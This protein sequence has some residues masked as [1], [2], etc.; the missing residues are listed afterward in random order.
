MGV[1]SEQAVV[2]LIIKGQNA[3]AT[4]KDLEK[5]SRALRAQMK[6]LALDSQEFADKQKELQKVEKRLRTIREELK[7]TGGMFQAIGKEIKAFGLIAVAAFGFQWIKGKVQSIIQNN[8]NLS[9]SFA[10]I[11]KTTEMTNREVKALNQTFSQMDTRTPTKELREIAIGAGQLG[12]AKHDV[13]EFTSAIDKMVVSL[14]DEFTGGAFEV[15]KTMGGLRNIFTDIKTDRVDQDILHIGNAVNVLAASGAATGP[16]ITDFANRIGGVGV[17]LGLTS[18]QV[19]GISATLQELSVTTERGGTAVSKILQKMTTNVAD[20]AKIADMDIQAFAKLVN[21]DLF[22]AFVKVVKGSKA[23]GAS[24]IAFGKILKELDVDGAGASEVVSKL[25]AN[26]GLLAEKV[27]LATKSIKNTDSIMKE[28]NLKNNTLGAEVD[29]LGKSMAAAFTN[30]KVQEGLK[31]IIGGLADLFDRSKKVSQVME[32]ERLKVNALVI[33]LKEANTTGERR[34]EIYEELEAINKKLVEGL[35]KENI[36][37]ERLNENLKIYNERAQQRILIQRKQEQIDEQNER[38]ADALEKRLSGEESARKRI[39]KI[40]EN[41]G[42]WS[43][44]VARINDNMNLTQIEKLEKIR[45]VMGKLAHANGQIINTEAR[46]HYLELINHLSWLTKVQAEH[47]R[48]SQK[49]ADLQREK[50]NLE[51]QLG[52]TAARNLDYSKKTEQELNNYILY[53]QKSHNTMFIDE[54]A[55]AILE[56]RRRKEKSAQDELI[57]DEE[58]KKKLLANA[59][60][61][62]EDLLRQ[63]EKFLLDVAE[64]EKKNSERYLSDRDRDKAAV[65]SK[66]RELLGMAESNSQ[67]QAII[68][69]AQNNELLDIDQKYDREALKAKQQYYQDRRRLENSEMQNEIDAVTKLYD[70]VIEKALEHNDEAISLELRKWEAIQEIQRKYREKEKQDKKQTPEEKKAERMRLQ[71]QREI[72][73][74]YYGTLN[75]LINYHNQKQQAVY[76]AE[77]ERINRS[78]DSSIAQQKRLLDNKIISQEEYDARVANLEKERDKRQRKLQQQIA[79]AEK[80]AATFSAIIN[81]AVAITE[82]W[83][84]HAANPYTASLLTAAA[85]ANTAL[86]IATINTAK[87]PQY[88]KGGYVDKP[89]LFSSTTGSKF[90]AGEAGEEWI[91]PNWMLRQP[92]YANTI[93]MLEAARQGRV[94]EKGGSTA[95]STPRPVFTGTSS[96]LSSQEVSSLVLVINKLNNLLTFISDNG[97]EAHLDYDRTTRDF[98]SIDN[99]RK[100][101]S[102]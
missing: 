88:A 14:G 74:A 30:S 79:Q 34:K 71:E 13:F 46:N 92:L 33:E 11:R 3:N 94:Y 7:G 26:A 47:N 27:D 87:V 4:M 10:D 65:Y 23:G 31:W 50:L 49:G 40:L 80:N 19:L 96:S 24:A 62:N 77:I 5:T 58:T 17:S 68:L 43:K 66:Y 2:E 93:G 61:H 57:L 100:S 12:I 70:D 25:G 35:N 82:I 81:G 63:H 1:Q 95:T 18:G 83:S 84:K 39:T 21:E 86:Q 101:A 28:F 78:T 69:E 99:A 91:A 85:V 53:N 73:Q 51:E 48:E 72:Y 59:K 16:V 37:V 20:F 55:A 22:G 41:Q 32:E 67:E 15:T 6:G 44:E 75:E 8:A 97:L 76:N 9:D 54:A 60:K 45:D 52:E 98:K 29:K 56:L 102:L 42:A 90:I 38:S 64:L 89:T 36:S